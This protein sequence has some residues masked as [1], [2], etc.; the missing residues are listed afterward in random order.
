MSSQQLSWLEKINRAAMGCTY[1][2]AEVAEAFTL[3]V[4]YRNKL[5]ADVPA[6]G[7]LLHRFFTRIQNDGASSYLD[8]YNYIQNFVVETYE[9]YKTA[10]DFLN[11]GD[12]YNTALT[13]LANITLEDRL[14]FCYV[15]VQ[16]FLGLIQN[17]IDYQWLLKHS[18]ENKDD[19]I[20]TM[21]QYVD[22]MVWA[23]GREALG[24]CL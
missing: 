19:L 16:Y 9:G 21:D 24:A 22:F 8:E 5:Y 13:P 10:K 3:P 7:T 20:A 15:S 23:L 17:N 12:F 14:P 18:F 11:R 2:E 1:S 4:D 6:P